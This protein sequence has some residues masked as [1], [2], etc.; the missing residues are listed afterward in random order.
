MLGDLR[1]F[2]QT[3][4]NVG[5]I[6]ESQRPFVSF[7]LKNWPLTLFAGMAIYGKL[8]ER[9]HKKDLT[10]Y[11]AMSDLGM[12]LSPIVGLA[13][14]SQLAKDQALAA[15]GAGPQPFSVAAKSSAP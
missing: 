9:H 4:Q 7:L 3:V 10:A 12:V 13:L 6:V 5:F 2:D 15:A 8:S 14:I 1:N 11:N